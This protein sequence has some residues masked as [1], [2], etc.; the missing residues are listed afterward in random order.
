M[1]AFT[2]GKARF[3]AVFHAQHG[4]GLCAPGKISVAAQVGEGRQQIPGATANLHA[5]MHESAIGILLVNIT[6]GHRDA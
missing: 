6:G 2:E 1:V 5:V 3:V 4:T